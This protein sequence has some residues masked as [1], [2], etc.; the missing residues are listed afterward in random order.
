MAT[1]RSQM[2]LNDGMSAI[3]KKICNGL[4]GVISV[5]T[6]GFTEALMTAAEGVH[7]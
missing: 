4:D 2:T 7:A 6:D 1:I 5:L 3:L